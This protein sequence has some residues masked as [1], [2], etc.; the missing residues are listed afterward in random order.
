MPDEREA[1][2]L[3]ALMLLHDSRR[4]A[5]VDAD[6]RLV[7]LADQDRSLL[8]RRGDRRGRAARRAR[9]AA[10][11]ARHVPDPGLDRGRARARLGLD[12]DRL[13]LRPA[14]RRS[15]RRRSSRSTARSPIAER[16]G[17]EAGLA[18]M[19]GLDLDG[20]HLFHAARADLLRRLERRDEA[21]AAYRAALALTDS[22]VERDFLAR[23]LHKHK[24]SGPLG[25]RRA[26]RPRCPRPA[27]ALRRDRGAQRRRP[28]GRRGRA[29]RAARAQRRRQ[30]DA[31][32]DRLR[33]RAAD[34]R[35][36][37]ARCSGALRLSRRAVPLPGL[38][39]RGRGAGAAPEARGLARR[40]RAS[41][42]EL[43]ELVGLGEVRDAAGRRDVEGHAAAARDRAGDDR[44][45]RSCCC[46]T[47]R[48]ARSTRR[49]GGRCAS[50]SRR[51]A[52]AASRCC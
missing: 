37:V 12:A 31:G 41:G 9:L 20:Y 39:E 8:G 40:A 11:P 21:A 44:R 50:C 51:C 17:P 30:V 49:G 47:S 18:L 42:A 29:G 5:R 7:L 22:E 16:D 10:R 35:A 4:A 32:E 13:A 6:G 26:R 2:G 15:R 23:R 3:L 34:E 43:L 14:A 24:G 25:S 52:S 36:A 1:I 46:S 19:D 48:R 38:A 27:Q 45:R 28:D 33:A